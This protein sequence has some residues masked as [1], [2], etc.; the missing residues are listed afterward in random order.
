MSSGTIRAI[1]TRLLSTIPVLFGVS[2]LSFCIVA[3]VP[4]DPVVAALGLEASPQA[5]AT[6]RA[7]FALDRPLP[8]RFAAWLWHVLHGDLGRSIESGQPVAAMVLRALGPTLEL[9]L[10]AL[11]LS[12]LVAVPAGILAAVR[13]GRP[14]DWI[15]SVAALVGL[16][17][18]SF[19]L[20]ILLILAFSVDARLLP[21]SGFVALSADPAGAMAHLALP[22][23]TLAAGLAAGMARMTRAAMLEVLSADY[24]RTARAKGLG[25]RDVVL[26]HGFRNALIPVV[27][28][29][30]LQFGQLLGGVVVTETIF[31]WP[32][33]GKLTVDAIFARDYPVVQGAILLTATL[34]VL[35]N[36]G[37][38]LLY[39]VLDPRLR[40]QG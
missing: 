18:P 24:I 29:S 6:L 7:Q 11:I 34:F 23:L 3:L 27:T 25:R 35:V 20:G 16:S 8:V 33:V 14:S 26:G 40:G 21:S 4:G 13:R 38:D 37:V 22:A 9:A 32:G 31:A 30:G 19:W 10:A 36:L 2:L 28:L 1:L 15:A 39:A 17:L 5:I 12:W